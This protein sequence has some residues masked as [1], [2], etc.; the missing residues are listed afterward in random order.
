MLGK[1][2]YLPATS[3]ELR[4]SP[5]EYLWRRLEVLVDYMVSEDQGIPIRNVKNFMSVI[6]SS[7]IVLWFMVHAGADDVAEAVHLASRIAAM[8]Y[9]FPIDDHAMTVK[10]DSHTYYRFQAP[11]L[12]PSRCPEADTVD[13][14]VYLCKRTMQNKHRLELADFEAER[15]ASLQSLYYHKWEFIYMQAEAEMKVDKKRDKLERVVLESQEAAFWNVHR[16]A[17]GCVNTTEVDM[18]KLCRAKRPKKTGLA[19]GRLH[20]VTFP[21][22]VASGVAGNLLFSVLEGL[23]PAEKV[24]KLRA[25]EHKRIKASKAIENLQN[26]CDQYFDFDMLLY[27]ATTSTSG[28]GYDGGGGGSGGGAVGS[29]KALATTSGVDISGAASATSAVSTAHHLLLPRRTSAGLNVTHGAVVNLILGPPPASA[30]SGASGDVQMDLAGQSNPWLSDNVTAAAENYWGSS[31]TVGAGGSGLGSAVQLGELSIP[32]VKRWSFSFQELLKDPLGRAKFQCW[33]EKEF[34]AENLMFWQ[35]CQDL[36]SAPL[37]EL[38]QRIQSIYS[39][40]LSLTA[41]E[42]VNVDSKVR[43]AVFRRLGLLRLLPPLNQETGGMEPLMEG[44]ML[45]PLS[46]NADAT[47]PVVVGAGASHA[48]RYCFE[49]AEE[50]IFQL[51]KSASYCRFLR[52]D[53]YR[54]LFANS[55]TKKKQ[56]KKHRVAVGAG[57][58]G[59]GAVVFASND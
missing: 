19:A 5:N 39:H 11:C 1:C 42:P 35:E 32:R 30:L 48:D 4:D 58:G 52:S 34:A 6:P 57:V 14:A 47:S 55:A 37:R 7:D 18:R 20:P 10:N 24:T 23:S 33:L 50:Q 49:E 51:M 28:G 29:S 8:G 43:E 21:I 45:E 31:T 22:P 2:V 26:Y 59:S 25:S 38:P 54:E 56:S 16:P 17:P 15:L 36:K 53:I 9:L 44:T 12:Y 46:L 13:Y 27:C 41:P 3:I 40:Y